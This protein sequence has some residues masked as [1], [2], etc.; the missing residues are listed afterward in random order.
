MGGGDF[1]EVKG[2]GDVLLCLACGDDSIGV[3]G[4]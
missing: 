1:R 2:K 4:A 3:G